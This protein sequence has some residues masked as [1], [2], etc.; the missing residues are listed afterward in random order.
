MIETFLN[1]V[2]EH[3]EFALICHV[4]PDGDTIGGALALKLAFEKLG[5]HADIFCQDAMPQLYHF[6]PQ[7]D[8]VRSV[9]PKKSYEMAIAVDVSD[10]E[11]MGSAACVFHGAQ[12]TACVD[13]HG[14][15]PGYAA[16]NVINPQAPAV[17]QCIF[18]LIQ[19]MGV[20]LDYDLSICLFV[21][22]S[23]DTFHFSFDSVTGDTLRA[24]AALVDH[25]LQLNSLTTRLYRV[26]SRGKTALMGS[27]LS[28]VRYYAG[29]KLSVMYVS[30]AEQCRCGAQDEDYEGIINYGIET[31][32][33]EIAV[34][35]RELKESNAIK[36]S[37][38]SKRYDVGALAARFGGGGH[39]RASGCTISRMKPE[40]AV[41][42]IV[43][44]AETVLAQ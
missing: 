25:G 24:A 13:H 20:A 38:R 34:L 10:E 22:I 30:Y 17:C 28:S 11:R 9:F 7:I 31:E 36:A 19:K 3:G 21:G 6:L 5:K 14:T 23:T 42:A 16:I 4:S 37:F 27:A 41:A 18:E 35:A 1:A 12:L 39:E 8:Q 29:G 15:N 2:A 40:D 26:R 44:A 33:V 43:R 32:G